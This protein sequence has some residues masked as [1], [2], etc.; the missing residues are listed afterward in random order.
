MVLCARNQQGQTAEK[1][2]L[3]TQLI[4]RGIMHA[5][6]FT[7]CFFKNRADVK[8]STDVIHSSLPT[9]CI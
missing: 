5:V 1:G 8:I 7:I 4:S 9:L 3:E 6:E 2:T